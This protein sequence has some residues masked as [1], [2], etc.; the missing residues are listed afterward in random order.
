MRKS[1]GEGRRCC[2]CRRVVETWT[3][4]SFIS[5]Y[6]DKKCLLSPTKIILNFT[7]LNGSNFVSH[8]VDENRMAMQWG[9]WGNMAKVI[10][11]HKQK[12]NQANLSFSTS[13][14][15]ALI[16]PASVAG[17]SSGHQ[18]RM[19][20]NQTSSMIQYVMSSR[21]QRPFCLLPK[22]LH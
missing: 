20:T 1:E 5:Y 12:A 9:Q 14:Y 19:R 22:L 11:W 16:G 13:A 8:S 4:L 18:R 15:P 21:C 17:S 10:I 6:G 3:S 7:I 2:C